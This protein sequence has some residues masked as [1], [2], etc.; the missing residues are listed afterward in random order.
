VG[1]HIVNGAGVKERVF[2]LVWEGILLVRGG[3]ICPV[4]QGQKV[5]FNESYEETCLTVLGRQ[6]T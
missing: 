4:L 3:D 1:T 6:E 5:L 2:G